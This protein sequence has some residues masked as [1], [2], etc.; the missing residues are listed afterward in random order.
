LLLSPRKPDESRFAIRHYTASADVS[1]EWIVKAKSKFLRVMF[2]CLVAVLAGC[3]P[4]AGDGT[5]RASDAQISQLKEKLWEAIRAKD[6]Q[7][8]L[9]CFFI[10]ERFKTADVH[11]T[12]LK[13]VEFL[14]G[15][16]ITSI[17][18]EEISPKDLAEIGK[19]QK[20]KPETAPRYSLYPKRML[21][22]SFKPEKGLSGR[23]F[24]IGEKGGQWYIV[25]MAGY[26]T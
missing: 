20:A 22:L 10:E 23:R 19:I 4:A 17:E 13:Q 1:I 9:D 26:T 15:R 14:L 24:L 25:T 2:A 5:S 3:G 16:E 8:F 18:I 7:K 21:L 12:N 6:A 11:Q